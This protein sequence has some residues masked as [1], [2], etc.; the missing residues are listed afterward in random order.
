MHA[1]IIENSSLSLSQNNC[2]IP[3]S[4]SDWEFEAAAESLN[5]KSAP[6]ED[7]ISAGLLLLLLSLPL[8]KPL[9]LKILNACFLLYFFPSP[10][11]LVKFVVIGKP[12]K[13]DYATL[14]SFRPISLI[15]NLAK[16]L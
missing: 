1:N 14:N 16:L 8:I 4:I 5:C 3:P 7:G 6:G 9:L 11:K 2:D 15:S 13:P 10:W 12:N